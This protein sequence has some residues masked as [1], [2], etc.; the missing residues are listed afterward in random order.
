MCLAPRIRLSP[1]ECG[2]LEPNHDDC[3][4][5]GIQECEP[6]GIQ[7]CELEGIHDE[8]ELI[9]GNQELDEDPEGSHDEPPENQSDEDDRDDIIDEPSTTPTPKPM[10]NTASTVEIG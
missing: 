5:D 4:L 1:Q 3:E 2:W 10:P 8:L 7:E 6:D 9:D